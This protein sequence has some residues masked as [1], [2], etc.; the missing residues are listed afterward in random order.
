MRM[1]VRS[2]FYRKI[3][4]IA[5]NLFIHGHVIFIPL[6]PLR[7]VRVLSQ[8]NYNIFYAVGC[9]DALDERK[10]A[11]WNAVR[12]SKYPA[13]ANG[14]SVYEH[15]H[16]VELKPGVKDSDLYGSSDALKK[17]VNA[18]EWV[19]TLCKAQDKALGSCFAKLRVGHTSNGNSHLK[20]VH[21]EELERIAKEKEAKEKE[22]KKKNQQP[23]KRST[24]FQPKLSTAKS[25]KKKKQNDTAAHG[26][27]KKIFKFV[28]DKGL[29]DNTVSDKN[30]RDMLEY[31]IEHARELQDYQ[32][33][34]IRK[35]VTI[36][37]TEFSEFVDWVA[38]KIV[39]IRNWYKENTGAERPFISV[40]HDVWD[41]KSKKIN[42]LVLFFMDPIT[43]EVYRI[44]IALMPPIGKKSIEL[45][46]TCMLGLDRYGIEIA[47]LWRAVN[48]TTS[49]SVKAGRL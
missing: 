22:K 9:F 24:F 6:L 11:E 38:N 20:R 7:L 36:Q 28:N 12:L 16:Q 44:P 5:N 31:T 17:A 35:F 39:E 27:H 29:P 40:A 25:T 3:S 26:L 30:F 18:D 47:D 45:R 4:S 37:C 1:P 8:S 32:H 13:G 42:G 21:G 15:I 41:G 49:A 19:C 14:S 33:L 43:G 23:S 46:D 48:D 34:G 2:K 10:Q